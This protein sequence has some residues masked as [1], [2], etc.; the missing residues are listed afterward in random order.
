MHFLGT[1]VMP[2]IRG[3][4]PGGV[5]SFCN[6]KK[7]RLE[8]LSANETSILYGAKSGFPRRFHTTADTC[9]ERDKITDRRTQT[10]RRWAGQKD[11]MM[12]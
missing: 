6:A 1:H 2:T 5:R 12:N 9:K 4:L 11:N 10:D 8:T 3:L 7:M